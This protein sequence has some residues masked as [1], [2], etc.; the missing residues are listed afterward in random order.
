MKGISVNPGGDRVLKHIEAPS[1]TPQI[2]D[3]SYAADGQVSGYTRSCPPKYELVENI[4][5]LLVEEWEESEDY[6]ELALQNGW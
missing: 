2:L 5:F 4:H 3:A 1:E 6:E